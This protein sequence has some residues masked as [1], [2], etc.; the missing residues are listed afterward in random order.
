MGQAPDGARQVYDN[1]SVPHMSSPCS[2]F[3][4]FRF[5]YPALLEGEAQQGADA[6]ETLS[7]RRTGIHVEPV[8]ADVALDHQQMGMPADEEV[9][10]MTAQTGPDA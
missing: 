4:H 2:Q 7:P 6:V 8:P 5:E 10:R 3:H 1:F 9:G